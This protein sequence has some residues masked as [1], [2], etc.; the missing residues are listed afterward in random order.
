MIRR[1]LPVLLLLALLLAGAAAGEAPPNVLLILADD[2]GVGDLAA[3]NGNRNRT[4]NLDRL[5]A[6]GLVFDQAWSASPVCAPA[7]AALLTGRYPHRT[8]VVSLTLNQEPELTRLK[9][10]ETTLADLFAANGHHSGLIGKWHTG[11]GEGYGPM[12]RGFQEVAVFHGSDKGGYT[13]YVLHEDD[14]MSDK[15]KPQDVYLTDELNRRAVAFVRRHAERP[16]FLHLAHYA[17][18]RPLQAPEEKIEPYLQ[19]GL[20]R[21][22]ATVYAMIEIM[23]RG[24]GELF[25]EIDRLG[26]RE[27]TLVIFSSDN[28]PDPLVAPRFNQGLRGGKYEVHEGGIRVP[29]LVRWPGVIQPGHTSTPIHFTDVLPTLVELCGLHHAPT[30]PLDGRSFAGLLRGGE[31][32]P[33]EPRFWQWNRHEPNHTHNA[34]MRDGPWKLVKP[35]VTKNKIDGDSNAPHALYR[36]DADPSESTDLAARHPERVQQMRASLEAWSRDVEKDRQR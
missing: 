36:L 15:P 25:T 6:E 23:D 20:D 12:A 19:A 22:T 8:G 24:L 27:R 3:F 1:S 31:A 7:R 29:F 35:F 14:R 16:F 30:L 26:L 28:G 5:A 10:D 2:M 18:H 11:L 4:P 13:R 21:D 9:R 32:A 34:A 17:P 33:P